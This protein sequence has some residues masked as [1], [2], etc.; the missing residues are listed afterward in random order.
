[1]NIAKHH[2]ALLL[3]AILHMGITPAMGAEQIKWNPADVLHLSDELFSASRHL[4]I[5]CRQTPPRY[6]EANTGGGD[7]LA[8]RYHV[9][10]F[11]SVANDLSE[12]L[13][14]SQG[15]A[16]T[17]PIYDALVEIMKDL[18]RYSEKTASGAWPAVSKA[19]VKADDVL[20]K[21]GAYYSE[22]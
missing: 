19:V 5:E 16:E 1:M 6:T 11:M 3:F 15:R 8:F 12:A 9:R 4:S 17:Q 20:A 7:H 18:Q 22:H 13:E 21:I 14:E 10:H 2:V